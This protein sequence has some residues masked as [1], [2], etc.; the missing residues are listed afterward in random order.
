[1]TKSW[2]P[3]FLLSPTF[4]LKSFNSHTGILFLNYTPLTCAISL[5]SIDRSNTFKKQ[6]NFEMEGDTAEKHEI[7][8]LNLQEIL[9]FELSLS[10]PIYFHSKVTKI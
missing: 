1:M 8:S 4:P 10:C 5:K 2:L 3:R 7:K 9:K 6:R